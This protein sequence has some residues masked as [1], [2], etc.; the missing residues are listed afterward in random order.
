MYFDG[1]S[2]LQSCLNVQPLVI[3]PRFISV[4]FTSVLK[5]SNRTKLLYVH[6]NE[7]A[8]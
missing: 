4:T 3:I 6:R 1:F 8:Y 5:G 7:V 2:F